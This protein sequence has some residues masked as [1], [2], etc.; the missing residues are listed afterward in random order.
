MENNPN[1]RDSTI[2]QLHH[3]KT[4]RKLSVSREKSYSIWLRKRNPKHSKLGKNTCCNKL[5]P[6]FTD[7]HS[8]WSCFAL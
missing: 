1:E 3:Y 2:P 8:Q 4:L 6:E 7:Q 5:D